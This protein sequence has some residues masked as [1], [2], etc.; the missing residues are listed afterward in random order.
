MWL[1]L[2][3]WWIGMC[4]YV[5]YLYWKVTWGAY[6]SCSIRSICSAVFQRSIFLPLSGHFRLYLLLSQLFPYLQ[7]LMLHSV[8]F[9]SPLRTRIE[10][11][12]GFRM[13]D[14]W[15][16]LWWT[17]NMGPCHPAKGFCRIPSFMVFVSATGFFSVPLQITMAVI[18]LFST[19]GTRPGDEWYWWEA[20]QEECACRT[21]V[22]ARMQCVCCIQSPLFCSYGFNLLHYCNDGEVELRRFRMRSNSLPRLI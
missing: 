17:Q 16:W 12:R 2:D 15:V 20:W 19:H 9:L 7:S 4:G 3:G 18:S 5:C 10:V 14:V 6:D 8:C 13:T 11:K 22:P 1:P 21:A